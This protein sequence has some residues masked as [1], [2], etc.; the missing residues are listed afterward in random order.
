MNCILTCRPRAGAL[1]APALLAAL[2]GGPL[3]AAAQE[4]ITLV[5]ARDAEPTSILRGASGNFGWIHNVFEPVFDLN[6]SGAVPI[7]AQSH[8][9]SE[10]GLTMSIRLRDDVTFHTGRR[11]TADDIKFTIEMARAPETASQVGTIAKEIE[12]I[13]VKGDSELVLTFKRPVPNIFEFFARTAVI[14]KETYEEREGGKTLIGTGPYRWVEW[15]PGAGVRLARYE[16]YRDPGAASIPNVEIVV[17]TDP[18]AMISAL[19]SGRAQV[20]LQLQPQYAI[21]FNNNP[22]YAIIPSGGSQYPLGLRVDTPPFDNRLVRQAVMYAIDR[23]RINEQIF[24]GLG[25]PTALF[26]EPGSMGY[27]EA[28]AN[29]YAYDPDRAR[30]LLAEAGAAG[31]TVPVT[32]RADPIQRGIYE[33]VQNNLS[34]VGLEVKVNVLD[35]PTFTDRQIAGDLG[36]AFQLLHGM[37]GLSPATIINSAPSIRQ[38]NPSHFWTDEYVALRAAVLSARNDA[39]SAAAIHALSA[40]MVEEA[41]NTVLVQAPGLNIVSS[42][43]DNVTF[44]NLNA[45]VLGKAEYK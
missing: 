16:G 22:N 24:D 37:V 3:A 18:T 25:T 41:F 7:L 42:G 19:R 32:I 30:A 23:E 4:T 44:S 40:Y 9:F 34:E 10:D 33:I 12:S 14:D 31:A 28:L 35:G 45:I 38:G 6:A 29:R 20:A 43:V 17:I 5:T 15:R 36:T 2:L 8:D 39:E 26:W 11:L 13:A 21:E 27:D 1:L